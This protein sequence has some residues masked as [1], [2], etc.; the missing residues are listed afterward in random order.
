MKI[1]TLIK[2]KGGNYMDEIVFIDSEIN[3]SGEICD[4]GAVKYKGG[5]LHTTSQSDFSEFVSGCKYVCGHNIIKHD[6]NYVGHLIFGEYTPIDTLIIS[7]LLFPK[8]PY[9]R[10]LKDYKIQSEQLND[11]ENDAELCKKLFFE[12]VD[13][14]N[15]LDEKLKSIYYAL[16]G[17][18]HEYIGFFNYMSFTSLDDAESIIRERFDDSI[19]TN[20]DLSAFISRCPVELAYCLALISTDDRRSIIPHWVHRTFPAVEYVMR[21]LRG[22][23]CNCCTFCLREQNIHTKL[24]HYF[25]Y[26]EFRTYD[27]EPL[28]EKA[29]QAAVDNKS[30]IAIFPTGGGKSVTFQLPALMS[31]DACRGL[32]VIISPLQSL[33]KDQVDNLAGKDIFD[34]VTINGLLDPI[35]RKNAI[36]RVQSGQASLLYISPESL[37]SK[38]IE[39]L[40]LNRHITRFVIDE[41]HC[42]SAWGQDFRVDYLYIGDFIREL[43]EKKHLSAPIPVSCF[44][45]TA[46]QKVI[47]DISDYFHSK[48]GLK[49]EIFASG[50]SRHNLHYKVLHM[51]NDEEKYLALRKLL[52]AKICPS[53]VYVS[54]VKRTFSLAARLSADGINALSFNGKMDKSE[55]VANQ[56]RFMSG[57]VNV[58]VAT[59]AFGMGVDKS[60]VGLVVHF[61]ISPSLEDYVQEAGRAGRDEDLQAECYVLFKDEDLDGHFMMLN[62]SKLSIKEINQIWKAVKDFSRGH[63]TFTRSALEIARCA[64]WNDEQG[65]VETRVTNAINALENAGYLKRGKN[66]P[67]VF[68]S[69]INAKN[70]TEAAEKINRIDNLD[71]AHK[72]LAARIIRSMISE[73]SRADAGNEDAESRV[74][75]LADSLGIPMKDVLLCIGAMRE[76]GVLADANDLT[77]YIRRN[78]TER[79]SANIL[80]RFAAL[81]RFLLNNINEGT[82]LYNLKELNEQAQ[83]EN[84]PSV[85]VKAIK[86]LLFF[87]MIKDYMQKSHI[88]GENVRIVL[89]DDVDKIKA[90]SEI[91]ISAAE[92]ILELLYRKTGEKKS[93][94]KDEVIVEFSELELLEYCCDN[95]LEKPDSEDVKSAL[96]YL[97]KIGAVDIEGGFLVLYNAMQITRLELKNNTR[98]KIEDYKR[99]SE[100]YDQK[101]QQIHIVGE[102]ANIMTRDYDA[103][104][105][106]VSDYFGMDYKKF[107]A[108]YFAGRESEISRNITPEKYDRIFAGLSP[109]Q[110]KIIDD[111]SSKYI[112]V[113]AGPGSGKTTVLVRKLASL[114]QMEDI[115]H[116]QL[117]MLTFSRA[118]ATEFR[119]KLTKLMGGAVR[120]MDIKTFHS[121]CFDISG[122]VGSLENSADIV[123][124]AAKMISDGDVEQGQITKTVAVIDEAQ[125][126]DENEF[127]LIKALM[128]RNE[129]MHVIAVGDDD[130]NI[131]E[132]RNSSSAHMASLITEYGA[133]NYSMTD[134]YRSCRKIVALA[135]AY[136]AKIEN[137]LKDEPI[138]AVRTE[139]GTVKLIKHTANHMDIPVA[140]CLQATWNGGTAAILT[141]T[142]DDA[143]RVLGL[144]NKRGIPARLIQ[145]SNDFR[146]SQLAEVKMFC[147]LLER[148]LDSNSPIIPQTVWN[149]ATEKLRSLYC[150]SAC[151][152]TVMNM[153][154]QFKELS[155]EKLYRSDFEMFIFE[156]IYD[157]FVPNEQNVVTISTIH[158]S[159]GREFDN[160]YIMLNKTDDKTDEEKRKIYVGIT[161]AKNALYIHY[162]NAIFDEIEADGVERETDTQDY[163]EPKELVMQLGIKDVFLDYFIG[164][165]ADVFKM[166]SGDEL[167]IRG[168]YLYANGK[169]LVIPSK[170]FREKLS[171]LSKRGYKPFA[172]QICFIIEWKKRETGEI[173]AVILPEIRLRKS[174]VTK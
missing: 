93:S 151:L 92:K 12:E 165:K 143:L 20:A 26:D 124:Q 142:N 107:I 140:D 48:L 110:Q 125:D 130:Q 60:D 83:K 113:T 119:Q 71:D 138:R 154:S 76:N 11:P 160:V 37:R 133:V 129:D 44:T 53:I 1:I 136:A 43:Q 58:I 5:R 21:A 42:F 30:L 139:D 64:G 147:R 22:T 8:R 90:K 153:L 67:R 99:L 163:P 108:K 24:K 91:R 38:T 31:G 84:V 59:S 28:Q 29:T 27:G 61:D 89:N 41:A 118:A 35:E 19:C 174:E 117:L 66:V 121:Y 109:C 161:R 14:F 137:R 115:K 98:Y 173:A 128:A 171:A 45:A 34:A 63:M 77:A 114:Y 103:A 97:S 16:L 169:K 101:I 7:P 112:V 52:T 157:S 47:S 55:K 10:L 74:D 105:R 80:S 111:D 149:A 4:L 81:E 78:D 148:D 152:E 40:M 46:K 145:S 65:D 170:A 33:M 69:S 39:N 73:R 3:H 70:Y 49:M 167:D 54:K 51:E 88:S 17:K 168:Y 68:A 15:K 86:T 56:E 82:E 32:T 62:Q 164:K 150:E 100:F 18:R 85:S 36:E 13:E 156:S 127:A 123:E 166:K 95:L 162:N 57:E 144:L 79:K 172:S 75:H 122:R 9:H 50:A 25:G 72:Q 106:F 132:F 158:K 104:L 116:E 102:Y 120:Y 159:K 23:P 87:F 2:F 155:G 131:Y 134:N 94:E 126:M 6:L 135:N 96:L 141:M 146:M